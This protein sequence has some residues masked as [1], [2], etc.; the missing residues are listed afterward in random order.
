MATFSEKELKIEEAKRKLEA[1]I[2][3]KYE[4]E[5][6]KNTHNTNILNMEKRSKQIENEISSNKTEKDR[7]S[8]DKQEIKK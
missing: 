6:E 2:E 5:T 8:N 4:I 7:V 1:N 3:K